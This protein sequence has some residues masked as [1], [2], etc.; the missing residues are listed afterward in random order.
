MNSNL[1]RKKF[2]DFFEKNQHRVVASSSLIP[3]QDP[4]ILF[5]NAGMNQ[6]K[7]LFLGNETRS[8]KRA[9]SSQKCVRAGGKHNDLDQVGFTD[10]HLTFFEMLGNFSFGDYFKEEAMKF[11]W[12]FLTKEI[13]IPEEKLSITI[14]TS[15]DEAFKL[16]TE[17]IGVPASKITRLGDED[18]FWQMGDTGPCGPCTEIFYDRGPEWEDKEIYGAK[19]TRY[20]EIWN[21]VFMQFNQNAN[22]ERKPLLQTGV[23]TGMGLE[24]LC[25]VLQNG[26][27][28]FDTDIFK[29]IF[30]E[31]QAKSGKVYKNLNYQEQAA[32]NVVADH[33]RSSSLIIADGGIPSNEGRGYVLRKI[34]RRGLL[35]LRK[36][37]DAPYLFADLTKVLAKS[38]GE[39]YPELITEQKK[40]DEILRGEID[41]FSAN[42]NRGQRYFEMFLQEAKQ[43]NQKKISGEHAFKLYDTYGFP[44]EVT[45]VLAR[46]NNLE[47]DF[48]GFEEEMEKQRQKS[49]G[50][51]TEKVNFEFP[52]N[53]YKN[54]FVGYD[55][56]NIA[57]KIVWKMEH[58]NQ[59]WLATEK[60]PFFAECGGQVSD[61]AEIIFSG[62][63]AAVKEIR[64]IP[65]PNNNRVV[66]FAVE[67]NS[68]TEKLNLGDT[69]EQKVD[70]TIRANTA[71]NHTGTH[72]L[73]AALQQVLG[74][75]VKQTGS[76]VHPDY[77]RFFFSYNKPMTHEEICKVEEI[78]NSWICQND[79]T[80]QIY[81][82]LEEANKLG[83]MA[84]FGEKY[85]PET[86]RVIKV[87]D[88]SVELCG[89]THVK[90][91]GEIG[92]FKITS[93][94]SGGAGNRCIFA[95]TGPK[96]IE[97]FQEQ[98]K[99]VKNLC[100]KFA[101]KPD[102]LEEKIEKL[103]C[104]TKNIEKEFQSLAQK[105]LEIV[106]TEVE[107]KVEKIG[108]CELAV[109]DLFKLDANSLRNFAKKLTNTDKDRIAIL[110]SQDNSSSNAQF[111]I[112]LSKSLADKK[113]LEKITGKLSELGIR[114]GGKHDFMQGSTERGK[115]QQLIDAVGA[116][117][118]NNL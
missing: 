74:E 24:R 107:K 71:K 40:I 111:F 94:E 27:T 57:S 64:S 61:T 116:A 36:I 29:I 105:H 106:A 59:V 87:E 55:T 90:Q 16:W 14:H 114:G 41:K 37:V 95:V 7:D 22:G 51:K 108:S 93:E 67:K 19:A 49:A 60:T 66:V 47:T 30:D 6:F 15:D 82:T 50:M 42:L 44:I 10:R 80:Q 9:A 54:E 26:E 20:L 1:V 76:L 100:T 39:T 70:K 112:M 117:I 84:L 53:F 109:A 4:T 98:N 2:L 103:S 81:T 69:V 21:L 88:Y 11:G 5:A 43:N 97:M 72:L 56:T 118:S 79:S 28:V 101:S 46:E 89:G 75:N 96:A 102:Q 91:T 92:T 31:L 12:D 85:N 32:F 33:L 25:M 99:V 104:D 63:S 38:L 52:S 86:V 65:T 73:Q 23:D 34:I 68:E 58:Q 17:K 48:A 45:H 113:A 13:Q 115:K 77:L 35:F 18:N 3:A 83:A 62:K 110:F 8:Y 78:V